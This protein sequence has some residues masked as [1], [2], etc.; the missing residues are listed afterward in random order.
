MARIIGRVAPGP[1][2]AGCASAVR[3]RIIG[4]IKY[5]V[6]SERAIKPARGRTIITTVA[7]GWAV[8]FRDGSEKENENLQF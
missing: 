1:A 2:G 6:F 3:A 5:S 7:P 4:L 8:V